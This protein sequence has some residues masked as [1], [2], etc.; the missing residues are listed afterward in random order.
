[1][2]VLYSHARPVTYHDRHFRSNAIEI[3]AF[4]S[5]KRNS[6]ITASEQIQ[7]MNALLRWSIEIQIPRPCRLYC[8][9]PRSFRSRIESLSHVSSLDSSNN[10]LP[11]ASSSRL[12]RRRD[13]EWE[14]VIVLTGPTAVGKTEVSLLVAERLNGEVVSADSV[15]VY[16]GLNVGSAKVR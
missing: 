11:E 14:K 9:C 6:G 2:N 13:K 4:G 8:A 15:Q 1:M 3:I 16:R 7:C 5:R 10:T 12:K